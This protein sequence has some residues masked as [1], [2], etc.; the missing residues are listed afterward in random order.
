MKL[1]I[2]SVIILLLLSNLVWEEEME[3][4]KV[5]FTS[6]LSAEGVMKVYDKIKEKVKGKTGVKVHFGEEGNQYYLKPELMTKLMKEV[7]GTFVE[8]NV[9]YVSKR[10]YTESHIQLAK[11]HGFTNAP[12]D[13]LDSA[14]ELVLDTDFNHFKKVKTGKNID[15][16]ETL[17][18]FSHFK[19][20]GLAG[21][22][23]AIKNVGMGLASIAGKMAMHASAIPHYSPDRCIKCQACIPKCPGDAITIDPLV[24]DPE[25]C[26]GCGTCIGI[27][28]VRAFNVP[29]GSTK[30]EVFLE[31]LTEYAKAIS[32]HKNMVY[33]NVIANVSAYCDCLPS[34]PAPFVDD[35]G[36]LASTDMLAIEKACSDLVNKAHGTPD[37]FLKESGASGLHQLKYAEK[38]GLGNSEYELINLD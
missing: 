9:L 31:R 28:P 23:G 2:I 26:I 24:I 1:P 34:A 20:H 27:C 38:I 19:G 10:R 18:I 29:W 32:D 4:P 21:F 16:Y 35:I 13:I 22:G 7:D 6:D 11:D 17:V 5:Y 25:K 30:K 8:T 36:V 12:I 37:A 14:G 3:K 15:N 33:I